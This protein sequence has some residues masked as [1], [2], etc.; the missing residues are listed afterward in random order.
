MKMIGKL[1]YRGFYCD[2]CHKPR[3]N[4]HTRTIE[5]REAA[6]EIHRESAASPLDAPSS[7]GGQP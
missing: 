3:T 1:R 4:K 7:L 6:R 5:K 2:C